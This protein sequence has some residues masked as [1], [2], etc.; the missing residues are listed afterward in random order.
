MVETEPDAGEQQAPTAELFGEEAVVAALAIR[1]V[2]DDRVGDMLQV[3]PDLVAAAG[4]RLHLKQGVATAWIAV[5][6]NRQFD[7]GQCAEMRQG[8][9]RYLDVK[10]QVQQVYNQQ[11][12]ARSHRTIWEQ[13]CSSWYKTASGKSTNN[14][15]GYTFTYRYLTRTPELADYDCVR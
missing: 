2:A 11:I 8:G 4:D 6:G 5:D 13:G 3:P 12:Q 7:L 9:L 14:W 1:C 10:P 15:P